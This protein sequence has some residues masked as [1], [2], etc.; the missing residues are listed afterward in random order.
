MK[1]LLAVFV[2]FS[3][4]VSNA[5][6]I[7]SPYLKVAPGQNTLV[8]R[9]AWHAD[10]RPGDRYAVGG[11]D[12]VF[13]DRLAIGPLDDPS[14]RCVMRPDGDVE[15]RAPW[16]SGNWPCLLRVCR[17]ECMIARLTLVSEPRTAP[18]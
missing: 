5:P 15:V 12:L 16:T 2:V 18:E 13:G 4:C 7:M 1:A 6:Q 8:E 17:D 11:P 10:W 3:G 9:D 14:G